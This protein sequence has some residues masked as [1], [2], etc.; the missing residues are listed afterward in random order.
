[1]AISL[2]E[3]IQNFEWEGKDEALCQAIS[4]IFE[5]NDV[6]VGALSRL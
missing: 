4:K 5:D 2:L 3:S 1:M 6:K